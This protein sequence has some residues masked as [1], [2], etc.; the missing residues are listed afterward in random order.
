MPEM[1]KIYAAISNVMNEVGAIG[2]DREN[3]TQHFAYRGID[4]VMNVM[5]PIFSKYHIF[6]VPEVIEVTRE[7]KVNAKGTTLI[8]TIAKM[9]YTLYAEDGSS[10]CAVVCG[11]GMDSG[12]K[13]T[14]KAM[15]IAM[16]YALFQIFCI[17][18]EEMDDPD[19]DDP[20][21][22]ALNTV[23]EKVMTVVKDKVDE[24]LRNEAY[25]IIEK[26]NGKKNP[27][28]ITDINVALD[29]LCALSCLKKEG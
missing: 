25:A 8:Y 20:Q 6:L 9:K 14:N 28:S 3:Q 17:P 12:D 7:D 16:K 18:T 21:E 1:P 11:E 5:H 4:D 23:M 15:A 26:I 19:K 27:K 29:V 10:V 13:S 24:G 2:K 22:V